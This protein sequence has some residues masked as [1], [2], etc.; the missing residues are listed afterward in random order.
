MDGI[1]DKIKEAKKAGYKDD[2]IVQLLT[3]VPSVSNQ[4]NAA[5]ENQYKP[6]EILKFLT[7]SKGYKAGAGLDKTTRALASAA[8]GPTFGLQMN[9]LVLLALQC[10][11]T[12]KAF[13]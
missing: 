2:E 7:Q 9:W 10:W 11:H 3:Q 5:L 8:G 12:K 13:H 6:D 4:V 1:E